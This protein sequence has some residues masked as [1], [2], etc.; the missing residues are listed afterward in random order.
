MKKVVLASYLA[1]T[2]A[3]PVFDT[4]SLY[5]AGEVLVGIYAYTAQIYLDFS[6]YTD[7]AI[8][9][10][11]LLG[12]RLPENF[13]RPYAATSVGDFWRRWHMSL[14]R[15]IRDFLF[16]PLA[17]RARGRPIRSAA[18]ILVVMLAIGVWH[19]A[20]WTFVAWGAA[21]GVVMVVER[22]ARGRRR[23]RHAARANSTARRILARFTTFHIVAFAWVL[24]RADS[25][26]SAGRVFGR[27]GAP[28]SID[29]VDPLLLTVLVATFAA[30]LIPPGFSER[31]A[32]AVER[33]G[34]V[35]QTAGLAVTLLFIDALGPTGVAP[36]I[37]FRF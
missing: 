11:L 21:H 33:V 10:G 17:Y 1:S 36:F 29:A 31:L 2:I 22:L 15:W 14:T 26:E 8:G 24:F 34:P 20:A 18:A 7:I 9:I 19:G 6:A 16:Q 37:Y 30:Q 25:L 35:I 3:D 27:L 28:G 13:D 12:A 32:V 23:A 5:S 4:P